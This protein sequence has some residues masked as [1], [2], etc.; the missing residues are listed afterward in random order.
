M[1]IN[2]NFENLLYFIGEKNYRIGLNKFNENYRERK[3]IYNPYFIN[4]TIIS[5]LLREILSLFIKED[6]YSII[7]GDFAYNWKF[8]LQW[9]ITIFVGIEIAFLNQ[10]F[11]KINFKNKKNFKVLKFAGNS[12][13]SSNSGQKDWSPIGNQ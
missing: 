6:Y 7:I 11:D 13:F 3:K 8:R 1:K 2:I 5:I 9:K 10:L 12:K 4:F